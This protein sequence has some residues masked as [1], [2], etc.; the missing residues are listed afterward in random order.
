MKLTKIFYHLTRQIN[1]WAWNEQRRNG[2]T[3][4]YALWHICNISGVLC[5]HNLASGWRRP[6]CV[7]VWIEINWIKVVNLTPPHSAIGPHSAAY[8]QEKVRNTQTR[9]H[10]IASNERHLN[11][12]E[13]IKGFMMTLASYLCRHRRCPFCLSF[14]PFL[15][16]I[17]S[18][19]CCYWVFKRKNRHSLRSHGYTDTSFFL[20]KHIIKIEKLKLKMM[21][22]DAP[23]PILALF[24]I[25]FVNLHFS[26][27][28]IPSLI[29]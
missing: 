9:F 8:P 22:W 3:H 16:R 7:F 19:R 26:H 27:A 6:F 4:E 20:L 24:F 2:Q 15:H 14:N 10:L 5:V 28:S 13:M 17:A 25:P 11:R 12:C 29:I 18:H 23:S 1:T 21:I